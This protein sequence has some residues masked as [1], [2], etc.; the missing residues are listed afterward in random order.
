M[1]STKGYLDYVLEQL[2]AAGFNDARCRAMMGGY[3]LYVDSVLIGG[4][5]DDRL[6]VKI[7]PGGEKFGMEEVVPYPNAK[8][9]WLVGEVDDVEALADVVRVTVNG[10]KAIRQWPGA[11]LPERSGEMTITINLL[12]IVV[13]RRK[14]APKKNLVR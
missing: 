7:V 3:L 13:P 12:C 1:V 6:L 5:Y 14:S 9:M 8:K 11:R 4:I 2:E 10:L